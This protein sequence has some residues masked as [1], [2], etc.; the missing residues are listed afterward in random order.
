[1]GKGKNDPNCKQGAEM[2]SM[3]GFAD[4]QT[5]VKVK[6]KKIT[7]KARAK[8]L[9]LEA[10]RAAQAEK[11]LQ[12]RHFKKHGV[13]TVVI[14][15]RY[16]VVNNH[17]NDIYP[18]PGGGQTGFS[19]DEANRLSNGLFSNSFVVLIEQPVADEQESS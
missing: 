1:M 2:N 15:D 5:T 19:L 18:S 6:T 10:G 17:G 4:A 16:R 14:V 8:A 13:E 11:V 12:Q 9:H 7:K 3:L